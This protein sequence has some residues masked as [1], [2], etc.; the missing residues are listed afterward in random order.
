MPFGTAT[1]APPGLTELPL[2]AV[3]VRAGFSKLSLAST[4]SVTG[5]SSG[6]LAESPAMS[7]T[8]AMAIVLVSVSVSGVPVPVLPPSFVVIVSVTAPL[9]SATGVKTGAEAEAR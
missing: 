1:A 7:A 2:T 3:M 6:V 4:A 5:V 8:G 9:A